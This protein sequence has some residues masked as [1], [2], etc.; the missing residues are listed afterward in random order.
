MPSA[1]SLLSITVLQPSKNQALPISASSW[2]SS[3]L[4]SLLSYTEL[5][6]KFLKAMLLASRLPAFVQRA[7]FARNVL[8]TCSSS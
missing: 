1:V 5:L 4:S 3:G 2:L 7:P 8:S 6:C